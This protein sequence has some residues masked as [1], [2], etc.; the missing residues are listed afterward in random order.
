M[1]VGS[2]V[3][4]LAHL[5]PYFSLKRSLRRRFR[6]RLHAIPI[7][8]KKAYAPEAV[9]IISS[10]S[11]N[12]QTMSGRHEYSSDTFD[13]K[14]KAFQGNVYEAL[15]ELVG[16]PEPP[17][18]SVW[19]SF[20]EA[21]AYRRRFPWLGESQGSDIDGL[22]YAFRDTLRTYVI[23]TF[24]ASKHAHSQAIA[25]VFGSDGGV[26]QEL[27][28][29]WTSKLRIAASNALENMSTVKLFAVG[30][31]A[32]GPDVDVLSLPEPVIYDRLVDALVLYWERRDQGTSREP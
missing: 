31:S 25:Q 14:L 4:Y 12:A 29:E 11:H 22:T 19:R 17:F 24:E 32:L 21:F 5:N 15:D 9:D 16:H 20:L 23:P 3:T 8:A 7:P 26:P 2:L 6:P 13:R 10:G 28:S 1:A 30:L 27:S 18:P